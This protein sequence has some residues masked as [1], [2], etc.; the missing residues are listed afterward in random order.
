[1]KSTGN[2]W[3]KLAIFNKELFKLASI[4]GEWWIIDGHAEFADDNTNHSG[5]VLDH[6]LSIHDIE[7][8]TFDL[9][10]VTDKILLEQGMSQEEIEYVFDRKDPREYGLKNLGWKRVHGNNIQTQTLTPEDIKSIEYGL[11][12][13]DEE[14]A[15]RKE[16]F[17]IEVVGNGMF[18][19]GVP[20]SAIESGNP[21]A[22]LEYR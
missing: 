3:F 20:Y 21:S 18:F 19:R 5:L 7:P 8:E 6:I 4:R 13:I 14:V 9:S 2:S 17:N 16:E 12:D 1:M 10:K 22:I 15:D 11:Y